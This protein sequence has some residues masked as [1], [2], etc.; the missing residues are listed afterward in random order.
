MALNSP[1]REMSTKYTFTQSHSHWHNM[2]LMFRSS[3]IPHCSA[4]VNLLHF[5]DQ[6][7]VKASSNLLDMTNQQEWF[8]MQKVRVLNACRSR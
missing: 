1:K 5:V 4:D 3:I 7:F 2:P 8:N 6:N